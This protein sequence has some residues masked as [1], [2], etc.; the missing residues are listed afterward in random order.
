MRNTPLKNIFSYMT[1]V[2]TGIYTAQGD[3][4]TPL[5]ANIV[6]LITNL[7][8]L[9]SITLSKIYPVVQ[10]NITLDINL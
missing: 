7:S 6:G 5:L 2:L 9:H 1:V 10:Y 3:S 4:K 8:V